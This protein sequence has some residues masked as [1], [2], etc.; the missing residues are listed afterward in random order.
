[1][2]FF[3]ENKIRPFFWIREITFGHLCGFQNT[4]RIFRKWLFFNF[5]SYAPLN[6]PNFPKNIAVVDNFVPPIVDNLIPGAGHGGKTNVF[7][8]LFMPAVRDT[9]D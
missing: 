3:P 1:M 5:L 8:S 7:I 2:L 4:N 6:L 9:S